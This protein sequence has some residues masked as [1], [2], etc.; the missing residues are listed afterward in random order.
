VNALIADYEKRKDSFD[1]PLWLIGADLDNCTKSWTEVFTFTP[2][3]GCYLIDLE[4]FVKLR[5]FFVEKNCKPTSVLLIKN[6]HSHTPCLRVT[7]PNEF[8]REGT[9][10]RICKKLSRHGDFSKS[11]LSRRSPMIGKVG[12]SFVCKALEKAGWKK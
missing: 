4:D 9:Y 1:K 3:E 11:F 10:Q 6:G 2:K 12:V 8:V 7:K 5:S